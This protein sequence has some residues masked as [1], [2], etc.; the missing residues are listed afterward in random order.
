MSQGI[1]ESFL[2]S[3]SKLQRLQSRCLD[4]LTR[5]LP[6]IIHTITR[7]NVGISTKV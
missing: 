7:D 2:R 6:E 1:Y 3:L 4:H 5:T